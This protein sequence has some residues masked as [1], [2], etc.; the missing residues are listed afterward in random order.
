LL[1]T[2]RAN[3][4]IGRLIGTYVFTLFTLAILTAVV[5]L[6]MVLKAKFYPPSDVIMWLLQGYVAMA[7]YS[8]PWV[9]LCAWVSS[10]IDSPFG[11]LVISQLI[12]GFYPLLILIGKGVEEKV[13]YGIYALPWGYKYWLFHPN[14]GMWLLGLLAMVAF[15]A[16]FTFLGMRHFQKRDL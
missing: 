3:I 11:S 7:I 12:I 2:E 14:I 1:R 4:F 8:L 16:L 6:Y 5:L 13:A 9:A 15:A 10:A